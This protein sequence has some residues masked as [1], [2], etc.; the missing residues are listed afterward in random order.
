MR[1]AGAY[2]TPSP[3]PNNSPSS[4][5]SLP[6]P[7]PSR[8]CASPS[9]YPLSSPQ[10]SPYSSPLANASAPGDDVLLRTLPQL[11]FSSLTTWWPAAPSPPPRSQTWCHLL[12]AS[13]VF[14]LPLL[15]L[16][17]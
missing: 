2:S 16:P 10:S 4:G 12:H 15:L 8:H 11:G 1:K 7:P 6:P 13:L 5:P 14:F 3:S 17:P 9:F